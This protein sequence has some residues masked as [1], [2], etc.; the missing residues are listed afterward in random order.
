MPKSTK[1][2]TPI[3]I[4]A[5][6]GGTITSIYSSVPELE[7][8]DIVFTETDEEACDSD[9]LQKVGKW[10]EWIYTITS[11]T[12]EDFLSA[13]YSRSVRA[14]AKRYDKVQEADMRKHRALAK[15]LGLKTP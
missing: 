10:G 2:K 12:S 8:V 13:S 6:S 7:G 4:V 3:V 15:K 1:T 9:N 11:A 5:M 14:A